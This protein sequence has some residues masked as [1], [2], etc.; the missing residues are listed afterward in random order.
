MSKLQNKIAQFMEGISDVSLGFTSKMIQYF[1]IS[2]KSK[3]MYVNHDIA[4]Q[5]KKR[6][7]G[8]MMGQ[9]FIADGHDID[10]CNDEVARL[11]GVND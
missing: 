9:K 8:S 7:I 3:S 1:V 11:F 2:E 5:E 4:L 6:K 10:E